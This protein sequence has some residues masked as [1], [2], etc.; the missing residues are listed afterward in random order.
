MAS[1]GSDYPKYPWWKKALLVWTHDGSDHFAKKIYDWAFDPLAVIPPAF[2]IFLGIA[3]ATDSAAV[4]AT[5][6]MVVF[7]SPLWLT[8]FLGSFFWVTWMHYIRYIFWFSTEHCVLQVQLPPEVTKS[9]LAMELFLTSLHNTGGE[10]TFIAR[11]WKGNY[12]AVW[13]LEIASNEGR[14]GFYIHLRRVWRSIIEARLYG[15][16]PE[17]RITEVDDY[18]NKVPFNLEEYDIF[19]AEYA[20]DPPDMLPIKTY[21]DYGLDKNP[22]TP[23]I[24]VD[25]ITNW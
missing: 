19:G 11:I 22:D 5:F 16:F 12:R 1:G 17:A 7:L 2:L 20:K 21:I 14:I 23:E 6:A 18:V 15:Q 8:L 10:T 13:T 4:E 9:P 25:P 3:A 24:Q